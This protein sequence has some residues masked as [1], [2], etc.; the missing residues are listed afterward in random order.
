M[1]IKEIEAALGQLPMEEGTG[2]ISRLAERRPHGKTRL[3]QECTR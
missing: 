1:S 3:A 2:L